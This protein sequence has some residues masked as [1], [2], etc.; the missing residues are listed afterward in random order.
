MLSNIY[1][2][3]SLTTSGIVAIQSVLKAR[4]AISK[5]SNS[6]RDYHTRGIRVVAGSFDPAV[7]THFSHFCF[8]ET[9]RAVG[10]KKSAKDTSSIREAVA[11]I[12]QLDISQHNSRTEQY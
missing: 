4:S 12:A 1:C 3:V 7:C 9:I 2:V 10:T 11:T 6:V 8:N 5:I